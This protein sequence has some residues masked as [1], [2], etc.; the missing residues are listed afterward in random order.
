MRPFSTRS[1]SFDS[2]AGSTVSDPSTATPTTM[3]VPIANDMKVALPVRNMPAMAI[4]TV[5]PGDEHGPAGG[6][7]GDLQ[8][9]LVGVPLVA[10]GALAAQVEQRVVDPHGEPDQ[11]D[12]RADH[13][14]DREQLAHRAR[15]ARASPSRR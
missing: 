15:A 1:P 12:H 9:P 5:M 7:G 3:I 10:F 11:Q 4:A 13:L 6:R 8:G 14:V 2:T